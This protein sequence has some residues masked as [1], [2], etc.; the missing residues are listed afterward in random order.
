MSR[1]N[2]PRMA[3]KT[4]TLVTLED[5]IDGSKAAETISFA[6]DG[7]AYEIDLSTK[8]AKA[9]RSDLTKWS[10]HARKAKRATT[11][12]A[13]RGASKPVSEA[14]AIRAWAAENGVDVPARGRIPAAVAEQYHAA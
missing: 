13:R 8:N 12:R 2:V 9:L 3:R 4:E 14:A 6:V 10:E 11:T 1:D 5:D 7:V